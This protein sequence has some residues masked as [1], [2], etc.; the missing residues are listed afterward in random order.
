MADAEKMARQLRRIRDDNLGH[1]EDLIARE[2][3]FD[4]DFC[5]S[6]YTANLRFTFGE[7]EKKGLRAFAEACVAQNLIPK[8]E[9][10]FDLL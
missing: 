6:Y 1:L 7:R 2:T 5:R 9:L 10:Q 4:A 3:E 8:R